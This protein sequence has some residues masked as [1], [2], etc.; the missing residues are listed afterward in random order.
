VSTQLEA[1]SGGT[2]TLKLRGMNAM[3]QI[4]LRLQPRKNL[5]INKESLFN[6]GGGKIFKRYFLL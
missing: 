3:R 6:V 2:P 1:R 4:L 5:F